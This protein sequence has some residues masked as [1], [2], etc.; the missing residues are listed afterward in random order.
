MALGHEVVR[1]Q[2]VEHPPIRRV[3]QAA[4]GHGR[5]VIG[6]V[7]QDVVRTVVRIKL[8]VA[9]MHDKTHARVTDPVRADHQPTPVSERA[10][11]VTLAETDEQAL[12]VL[13]LISFVGNWQKTD[14]KAVSEQIS[15]GSDK[16]FLT[17]RVAVIL[18]AV[19]V[20][21]IGFPVFRIECRKVL[22]VL[23]GLLGINEY[24]VCDPAVRYREQVVAELAKQNITDEPELRA[25]ENRIV[26][27]LLPAD[28][29][30]LGQVS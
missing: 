20:D 29:D 9:V 6:H 11:L 17:V 30:P 21:V 4:L 10:A 7:A 12:A 14:S 13:V 8:W 15:A 5:I 2:L 19:V 25:G 1:Q 18:S 16:D 28:F 27:D 24:L 22:G 26:E 3:R 23:H